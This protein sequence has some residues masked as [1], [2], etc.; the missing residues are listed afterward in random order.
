MANSDSSEGLKSVISALTKQSST[1]SPTPPASAPRARKSA[2]LSSWDLVAVLG[3]LSR[4]E[5]P[6]KLRDLVSVTMMAPSTLS[7]ALDSAARSRLYIPDQKRVLRGNLLEF[8]VHGVKYAFPAVRGPEVRGVPT[9]H[10]AS[11]LVS[12]F[13]VGKEAGPVWPHALGQVRG[14]ALSPLHPDVPK[15]ALANPRLH[16]VYALIDAI[17]DGRS[18][19]RELAI[20]E[21]TRTIDQF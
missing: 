2:A 11:P 21:L 20:Q 3:V 16:E 7:E 5:V 4:G 1:A 19:E 8:L 17:R 9:G 13:P 14:Y 18:R 10:T 15:I 6:W 12:Q